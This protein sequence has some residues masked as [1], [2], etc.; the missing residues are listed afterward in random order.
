MTFKGTKIS[1]HLS[2]DEAHFSSDL[3]HQPPMSAVLQQAGFS[4]QPYSTDT[5]T[6]MSST[7][8]HV[9]TLSEEAT[10]P[11]QA[12]PSSTGLD[13]FSAESVVVPTGT[14]KLIHT[15]ISKEFPPQHYGQIKSRNGLLAYKYCLNVQAGTIDCNHHGEIGIVVS[16]NSY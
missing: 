14:N 13:F 9:K 12:M 2:F 16:N 8:L 11:V 7:T 6:P 5:P 15:N 3:K 4:H 1:T 10:T